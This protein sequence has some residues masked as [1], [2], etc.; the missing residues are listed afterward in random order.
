MSV[1]LKIGCRVRLQWDD[2]WTQ[3]G[4]V[5]ARA[6]DRLRVYWPDDNMFTCERPADL[7]AYDGDIT[8]EL[9]A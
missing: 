4:C 7:V 9:V 8:S 3:P 6:G 1:L 5:M 2:G